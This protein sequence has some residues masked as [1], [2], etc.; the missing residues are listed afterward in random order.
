ML[1]FFTLCA[2]LA[3]LGLTTLLVTGS[4]ARSGYSSGLSLRNPS[5]RVECRW[6]R[7]PRPPFDQ[8]WRCI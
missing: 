1:K 3:L 7:A 2:C 8:R 5:H 4:G 6:A